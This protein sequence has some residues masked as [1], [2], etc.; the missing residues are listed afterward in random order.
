MTSSRRFI[1]V[2]CVMNG[3]FHFRQSACEFEIG[4]RVVDWIAAENNE[5]LY[6]TGFHF[7]DKLA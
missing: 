2:Q 1:R 7:C 6:Y 3:Q 4:R 5:Q